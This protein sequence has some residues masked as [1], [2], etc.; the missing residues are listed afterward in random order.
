MRKLFWTTGTGSVT[1]SWILVWVCFMAIWPWVNAAEL[2]RARVTQIIKDVKLLS[3][4]AAPRAAAV[5][6]DVPQG[7]AVRT[8]VESRAELT[9]TDLTITR[10]GANT[11]FSFNEGTRELNLGSGAILVEVPKNAPAVQFTTPAFTGGVTGGTA[12]LEFHPG[13][14]GKFLILEGTGELCPKGNPSGCVTVHAGEMV[15]TTPEGH[16]SQPV[17]FDVS[18]LYQTSL[19]ITDFPPLPN[20]DL[21]LQVIDQQQQ[22]LNGPANPSPTP[23]SA[24]AIDVLSQRAAASPSPTASPQIG[25]PVIRSPVPYVINNGTTIVT[26]PTITTNGV[27]DHGVI[28][29]GSAVDG[30]VSTFA[31]GSTSAFD[32]ASGFNKVVQGKN[33]AAAF[34][35][36]SLQLAGNP[37][38]D[39]TNGPIR[40]GLIAVSGITSGGE[41]SNI[42]FT[43][44]RGVLLAAQDGSVNLGSEIVFSGFHD[45]NIYARG[46]SSDL[47][48]GSDVSTE[49][50]ALFAERDMSIT[51]NITTGELFAVAGRDM[52]IGGASET[53]MQVTVANGATFTIRGSNDGAITFNNASVH[54]DV[55]KVGALG[56]NG[57]LNI[58]GGTLSADSTLKLYANSSNGTVNFIADVTLTGASTKIIAGDTVKVFDGVVVTIGVSPA[59]IYTNHA[60]YSSSNGGDGATTGIFT[61][62]GFTG[63]AVTT[64]LGATPPPFDDPPIPA[65]TVTSGGNVTRGKRTGITSG[66]NVTSGKRTGAAI[67]VGS[68]A[69]LLSLLDGA[70]PGPDGKLTVPA[71]NSTRNLRNTKRPNDARQLNSDPRAVPLRN[72]Q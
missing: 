35:F 9:F 12:I 1:I 37:T 30:P 72:A 2:K 41:F 32:R 47:T 23:T 25:P 61:P 51:S 13:A 14:P 49:H 8:G 4:R 34:K 48:L 31:F 7:T 70:A 21:I 64:H 46:P 6:E 38:I 65:A 58:G 69:Q 59:D 26:H 45:L 43:G 15:M 56:T 62:S 11:I 22:A 27:T 54:A 39:T 24:I 40:L 19:L 17:Q 53:E 16:I 28:Y 33:K 50:V 44:L 3:G 20:A 67:N 68:T 52:Q 36:A 42:T 5:S 71:S 63:P 10:L 66:G 57:V 18:K 55:L 29:H 60:H